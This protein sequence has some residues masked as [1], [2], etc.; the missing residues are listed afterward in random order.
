M[1]QLDV[2]NTLLHGELSDIVYMHQPKGFVHPDYPHV[3][4]LHRAL[5]GLKQSP[6]A[7]FHR[8]SCFL[9]DLG[10]TQC[11]SDHSMFI[12]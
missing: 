11:I 1:R 6:H 12:F 4:K 8:L 5:Y 10:F 7:W 3:C 2:S 9:F